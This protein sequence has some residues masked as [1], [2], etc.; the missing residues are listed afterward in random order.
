MVVLGSHGVPVT[1]A[2]V[3]VVVVS[4]REVLRGASRKCCRWLVVEVQ[5]SEPRGGLKAVGD[6]LEKPES[7]ATGR[8]LQGIDI[9]HAL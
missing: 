1:R 4:V 5:A 2:D 8:A 7:S 6:E 3:E 9:V